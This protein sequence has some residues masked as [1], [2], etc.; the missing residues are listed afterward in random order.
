MNCISKQPCAGARVLVSMKD[1][2]NY[3]LYATLTDNSIK[4]FSRL[5]KIHKKLIDTG[6]AC[7]FIWNVQL[8]RAAREIYV[9]AILSLKSDIFALKWL[10]SE[11]DRKSLTRKLGLKKKLSKVNG[12]INLSLEPVNHQPTKAPI[13]TACDEICR[14]RATILREMRTEEHKKTSK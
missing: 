14:S 5:L 8:R 6:T 10:L 1:S 9:Q 11:K 12:K 3:T 2:F 7:V 4:K 13:K